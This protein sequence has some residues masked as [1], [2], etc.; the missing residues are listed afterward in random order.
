MK[1]QHMKKPM[2]L[3]L[4]KG[5]FLRSFNNNDQVLVHPLSNFTHCLTF[6]NKPLSKGNKI[7]MAND[8]WPLKKIHDKKRSLKCN[9]RKVKKKLPLH[10]QETPFH[11]R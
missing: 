7:D 6:F 10:I 5:N 11:M 9:K 4:C 8:K 1:S 3:D 2:F